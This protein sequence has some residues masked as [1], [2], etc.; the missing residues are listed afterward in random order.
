[1]PWKASSSH[2]EVVETLH[3]TTNRIQKAS[4]IVIA[5]AGATGVELSGEIRFEFPQ[6]TVVL[7]CSDEQ[8]LKGDVI[9]SATERELTKL[10]V[11]IRKGVRVTGTEEQGD[12]T[13]VRLDTGEEM[14]TELYLPTMGFTPNTA[15][16]PGE[17][18]NESGY[19]DVNEYMEI[20][21]SQGQ[22]IWAVGDVISKP[23]AGFLITEAQ[24]CPP[25]NHNIVRH[26]NSLQAAGVAKNIDLILRGKEQQ[27]VHGPAVDI[28]IC[29]TGRSRAA[30][31]FGFVPIPSL[32]AWIGKGRTLGI[33]R[34]KKYVDGSMW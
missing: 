17:F 19:V 20:A 8:V 25:R 1:M 9:A 22:G 34:T 18:L 27:V 6:K 4:H 33:D 29:S 28:F 15:C 31:R 26:A 30:G 13:L 24:A 10:G 21:T 23:R 11:D 32:A 14:E 7:L 3:S 2:E 16:L 5:G 12:K